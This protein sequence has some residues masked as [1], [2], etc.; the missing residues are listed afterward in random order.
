ML[1]MCVCI[2]LLFCVR[3]FVVWYCLLKTSCAQEF[4]H[5]ARHANMHSSTA[6]QQHSATENQKKNIHQQ[7]IEET[8]QQQLVHKYIGKD[9]C[10]TLIFVVSARFIYCTVQCTC[11]YSYTCRSL[12]CFSYFLCSVC[13]CLCVSLGI[14]CSLL[15]YHTFYTDTTTFESVRG[16]FVYDISGILKQNHAFEKQIR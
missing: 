12:A 5:I 9:W 1:W 14:S 8:N 16:T 2:Y 13:V 10:D 15:P 4:T 6:A 3:L 7:E 11:T